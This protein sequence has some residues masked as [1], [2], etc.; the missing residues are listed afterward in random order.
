MSSLLVVLNEHMAGSLTRRPVLSSRRVGAYIASI[1][2]ASVVHGRDFTTAEREGAAPV[3]IVNEPFA[4]RYFPDLNPVGQR[5]RIQRLERSDEWREVVGVV[6]DLAL[7]PGDPAR[8]D[9]VYAPASPGNMVRL[10]VLVDGR[11][12]HFVPVI[13]EVARGVPL[14]PEVQW[15]KTLGAQ[16]AEPVALFRGLGVGLVALGGV[17]LVLA[18]TGIHAIVAF[19]LAQRRREL[20]VRIAL[21]AGAATLA[22]ALLSRTLRQLAMGAIGG[23]LV[24]VLV[25]R[26]MDV[27]PFD[28]PRGD[29]SLLLLMMLMLTGAGVLACAAPLGRALTLRPLDWLR[30]G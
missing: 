1:A 5:I 23:V 16:M 9:G 4:R 15:T 25:T 11:P 28:V 2:N 27:I 10:A 17:A 30:E 8:G 26:F 29:I 24:A 6:P 3:A 7:N 14:R 22:R 19:S 13:H 21:G 20:A 18:C 12:E